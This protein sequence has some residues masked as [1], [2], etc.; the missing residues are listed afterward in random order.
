[1]QINKVKQ[2]LVLVVAMAFSQSFAQADHPRILIDCGGLA[3]N[4]NGYGGWP[5]T[6]PATYTPYT[7]VY[8]NN[9]TNYTANT[10]IADLVTTDN[11]PTGIGVT[12]IVG[13]SGANGP[14]NGGLSC[15]NGS[16][17]STALLGDFGLE[18]ATEDFFYITSGTAA[19]I[20]VTGLAAS[21]TYQLSFFGSRAETESRYTTNTVTG[22]NGTFS[23]VM[24]TTGTGIGAGGYSGNN[25]NIVSTAWLS[26]DS[27]NQISDTVTYAGSAGYLNI[28]AIEVNRPPTAN[29]DTVTRNPGDPI[30]ITAASLMANDTDPD[31]DALEFD[32]FSSLPSGATTNGAS[33]T[34][35]GTNT[36]QTFAYVIDDGLGL[37][38]TG[39]VTVTF[40]AALTPTII[41]LP[42]ASAISY[43]QTLASSTLTGGAATNAA[44]GVSVPGMFVFITPSV[45]PDAGTTNVS[46]TFTAMDPTTYNSVTT[47]VSVTVSTTTPALTVP[48]ASPIIF[49]Q[50]LASSTLSG[51]ATTNSFNNAPVAGSFAYADTTMAP[52]AGSTYVPVIFTPTDAADYNSATTT[53]TV[54]VANGRIVVM[55]SS[56]ALGYG[57]SGFLNNIYIN[58][59]YSNG[60][61]ALLTQLLTPEGWAVTNISISGQNTANGL[62]R[63]NT[64]VVP[65]SPNYLWIG[66]SLWNEG[67]GGS[68][69][70]VGVVTTYLANLTNLISKC[71]SN[72]IYNLNG[73]NYPNNN[74]SSSEYGYL[75]S[76]NLTINGWNAPSVNFLGALD[77]G[78]GH[79]VNGYWY[80]ALHPNDAGYAEM[81]YSFVP[82]LFAAVAAGKT[83]SPPLAVPTSF[84]RLTQDGA[85]PAPITFTPSNTMH[86]FTMSFRVRSTNSGTIAAVR[87]GT[88]YATIQIQND[89]L[90]YVSTNGHQ[91]SISVNATNGAWHDVALAYRY[92]LQQT[93]LIVDGTVAG[94]L[95]EQYVPDQF[96]LGG[97]GGAAGQPASPLVADFQNWC[98]YR[99]A[100]NTNEALAQIQGNRQQASMEVCATLDD[101]SFTSGS[102]AT[103]RAQSLSLAMVN[104]ANLMP[105]QVRSPTLMTLPTAS[106]I[107]YGQTL[108]SSTLTGGAVTNA[109]DGVPVSGTFTFTTPSTVPYVGTTNV[110][111]TFTPTD[112]TTYNS[113][114]TNVSVTVSTT[115]PALRA[116]SARPIIFGQTLASSTL[117]G[118]AATNSF[119]NALVAGS[120]AYI[121]T[122]I[123]PNAVS[124]NVSIIF[125]PADTT[126]YNSVTSTV[127]V[128]VNQ[129]EILSITANGN[130]G[131]ILSFAGAPGLNYRLQMT[132]NLAAA[133][134][135]DVATSTVDGSGISSFTDTNPASQAQKFYRTV[136]P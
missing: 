88:N 106:A 3:G 10:G 81:F 128:V 20:Q 107:S 35:P 133:V 123:A 43:G 56:V 101:A 52:N 87:S 78:A 99:A 16:C 23:Y 84:A 47:D 22:G 112:P 90:V 76:A 93:M 21:N 64:D 124:T 67:L 33:I 53:V 63:F 30:T 132:T 36:I 17:P 102:P 127:S 59:S 108:A 135:T 130:P 71:R 92:A 105:M 60:Y 38:S 116:P 69:N 25:S 117:S 80:D 134:W 119:N 118:G 5:T 111:V 126:D 6:S 66:Y 11:V 34:L 77:D 85:V 83:N 115:T 113:F 44:D 110:S 61:A 12:N 29:N 120:F 91:I 15:S 74:Y 28:L 9:F 14:Q 4:V 48:S 42:T 62:A 49:G 96:I 37:T 82:T 18:T 89:Q 121:D 79:W 68:T 58:G 57:S 65:L 109:A 100:W 136:Y 8:W 122:T 40:N 94:T 26:P 72:G 103:N 32:N 70:P 51:G 86:S 19:T 54:S 98:V 1:M 50:T 97:P 95:S 73:L 13:W 129:G 31:G 39:T 2:K 131:V 104:T 41:A 55:G 45:A 114:T 24:Q 46:V 7:N 27:N 125:I 75:K